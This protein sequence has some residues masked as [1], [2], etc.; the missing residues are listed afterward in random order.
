MR[1]TSL[2]GSGAG[3]DHQT[4]KKQLKLPF[5]LFVASKK[6]FSFVDYQNMENWG[7]RLDVFKW[8]F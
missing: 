7:R 2:E 5:L 1:F 3:G 4:E 8:F 6:S